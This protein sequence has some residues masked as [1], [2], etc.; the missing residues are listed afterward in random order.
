MA[1]S[2]VDLRGARIL[3][4][5][6]H[7]A[8]I[9]VI[10]QA[11]AGKGYELFVASS[12]PEALQ[13]ARLVAPELV[14][15]DVLMPEMDGMEVC[16]RMKADAQMGAIPIVF[17]TARDD[18]AMLVAGFS[19]G[20]VDYITKPFP[21]EELRTWVAT[22]VQ[23][24]RLVRQQEEQNRALAAK[25]EELARKNQQLEDEVAR[26]IRL[27]QRLSFF[28]DQERRRWGVADFVG[29]SET[30]QQILRSV[31]RLQQAAIPVLITGES[32][33]GKELIARALH[34][35]GAGGEGPFVPVNCSAV[36]AELAESLFFGHVRGAFSGADTDRAG[37]FEL[38]HGGT[39]F[40]DEVGDMPL[41][42]QA[43]LLRVL[44]DGVVLPV[45]GRKEKKVE[46]RVL[47]ATNVDLVTRIQDG[48]F[49]EDLYFRLARFPVRVPPLRERRE[50]IPLLARHFLQLFSAELKVP[51]PNLSPEVLKLLQ[52]YAFPGNVRELRNAIE[53]ALIESGG[54]PIE[55]CHVHLSFLPATPQP[56]RRAA[57]P[58]V[59]M[60]E[61]PLDLAAAEL[62]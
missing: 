29:Q 58:G 25:N 39:L 53:R 57:P 15:L 26:R 13:V 40:L 22:Q 3:I 18:M 31:G 54:G 42:L 59:G 45:G 6:D 61:L 4:V 47:A 35:G 37:Y 9:E 12:G 34:F 33:T 46:V 7:P 62:V 60:E 36:P 43:K 14:L 52:E 23:L 48:R 41:D 20:G 51:V 38:A 5:D 21:S 55:G 30:L 11:L 1:E 56:V 44:E 19:A 2:A 32:G 27:D 17:V 28:S 10:E 24:G 50:D 16:R 8:N 49:R